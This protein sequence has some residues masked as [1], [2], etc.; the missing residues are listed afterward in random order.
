[1]ATRWRSAPSVRGRYE[2]PTRAPLQ[3]T[4]RRTSTLH[5]AASAALLLGLAAASGVPAAATGERGSVYA[6]GM[7]VNM[8]VP[9]GWILDKD[10][11]YSQGFAAVMYP[12]VSTW[13]TAKVVMY[14]RLIPL[15]GGKTA[16]QV[17]AD[18]L[19]GYRESSPDLKIVADEPIKLVTGVTAQVWRC[20]HDKWGNYEAVAY[21]PLPSGIAIWVLV[22][23]N[24]SLFESGLPNFR[25]LVASTT[26]VRFSAQGGGGGHGP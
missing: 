3:P 22:S 19:T 15:G 1:M 16:E 6:R 12:T 4:A 13:D 23:P 14:L 24:P 7:A 10:A 9:D 18:D 20:A 17:I 2:G 21:L 8:Q 25:A 11:G 5:A 26:P